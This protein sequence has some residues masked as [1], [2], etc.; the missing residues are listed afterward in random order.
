MDLIIILRLHWLTSSICVHK[1][2]LCRALLYVNPSPL[3][4]VYRSSLWVSKLPFPAALQMGLWAMLISS[5]HWALIN[6]TRIQR[7]LKMSLRGL[8]LPR[9]LPITQTKWIRPT[10]STIF[11]L[12]QRWIL[13]EVLFLQGHI[14]RQCH[15]HVANNLNSLH[16]I[17]QTGTALGIGTHRNISAS[18]IGKKVIVP[19][20][21]KLSM[22]SVGSWLKREL[23]CKYIEGQFSI[24]NRI[25]GRKPNISVSWYLSFS[26]IKIPLGPVN[27]SY[28]PN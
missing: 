18:A 14:L 24:S 13:S 26:L 23:L 17:I 16:Q 21:V 27:S 8:I 6:T 5:F 9:L 2:S 10:L 22:Y 20:K 15:W 1:V 3:Y 12:W 7:P 19:L 4:R 28:L 11:G 25:R